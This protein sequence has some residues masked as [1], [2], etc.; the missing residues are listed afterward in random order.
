MIQANFTNMFPIKYQF[1]YIYAKKN[2]PGSEFT[3]CQHMAPVRLWDLM[4][5]KVFDIK[6][7]GG[8]TTLPEGFW[9]AVDVWVKKPHV[10]NKRLCGV[11]ETVSEDVDSEALRFLLDDP[12]SELSQEVLTFLTCRVLPEQTHDREKPWSSSVRTFIPKINSYGT[13]MHKEFV[14]KGESCTWMKGYAVFKGLFLN[15]F[16]FS[17]LC[18]TAS[19]L[20]SIW[21]GC[22][23]AGVS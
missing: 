3:D 1:P 7:P 10:V 12:V 22:W 23:R 6:F 13:I 8:C 5:P 18:Q 4:M 14:L 16:V 21:R 11:K 19:D 9:S 20:S 17:R 2:K 15:V